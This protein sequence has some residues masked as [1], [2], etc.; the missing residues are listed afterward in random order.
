MSADIQ[1]LKAVLREQ[2]RARVKKL[3]PAERAAASERLC[4]RLKEQEI[5]R[6]AR[7]ILF[8]APLP[9]EPDLW[10]L[11]AEALAKDKQVALPCFD[12]KSRAYFARRIND[13]QTDVHTGYFGIREPASHCPPM[14]LNQLDVVLVPGVAFD[15][16]GRRLGRGKG[17]YD[18]LLKL[19]SGVKCG[20]G[21]D[22]QLVSAIPTEP[23][24]VD[25][26]YILT[27]T[28]WHLVA[29]QRAVLK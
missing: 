15:G 21:F 11:L 16:Q 18:R 17:Y 20:V 4:A 22:E 3:S 8:F 2:T 6:Q 27:P 26:N 13:P 23:H 25:L 29:S 19:V 9:D 10:R 24:D 14:P 12:S 1:K 5:W 28:R 7:S